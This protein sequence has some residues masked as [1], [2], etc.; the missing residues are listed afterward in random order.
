MTPDE[1]AA[2]LG[3]DLNAYTPIPN[4]APATRVGNTIYTSGH[5]SSGYQGKLGADF[6]TAEGQAAARVCAVQFLQAAAT[7]TGT[8]NNLRCVKLLG[9]VNCTTDFTEQHLVING[10]SQLIWDIF[11]KETRG[12]HA[13]SALGFVS[14]PVGFAV[15]IEAIFEVI[16][17][18]S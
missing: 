3:I 15:E 13:R 16:D 18:V 7:L 5:V 2:E 8:L 11:G 17:N 14:L 10:A 6:T 4:L 1:K 12:Y 9:A